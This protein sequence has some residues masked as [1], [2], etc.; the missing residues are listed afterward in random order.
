VLTALGSA[1]LLVLLRIALEPN[2]SLAAGLAAR[3]RNE[4][5]LAQLKTQIDLLARASQDK[6]RFLASAVHDLPQPLHALGLFCAALEQ[7]LHDIPERPLVKNM[8]A[9]IE[10]LETSFGAMLDISRLD[11]GIVR[12]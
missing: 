11:A 12:P 10:A 9:S 4:D 6:T 2:D 7:R 3:F 8:M 1:F 5:L